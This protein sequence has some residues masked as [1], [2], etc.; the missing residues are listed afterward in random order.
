MTVRPATIRAVSILLVIVAAVYFLGLVINLV[1]LFSPREE[2]LLINRPISD[3]FWVLSGLLCLALAIAILW[4][5][6]L[7]WRGDRAVGATVSVLC[8]ITG[9]FSLFGLAVG[10]GWAALAM[11]ITILVLNSSKPSQRWYDSVTTQ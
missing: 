8:V 11:S 6:R 4:L 2:Q 9:A 7:V 10:F 3:W 1:L 5:S